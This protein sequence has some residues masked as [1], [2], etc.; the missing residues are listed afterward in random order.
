[1]EDYLPLEKHPMQVKNLSPSKLKEVNLFSV[2][3]IPSVFFARLWQNVLICGVKNK[4]LYESLKLIIIEG[5]APG[6]I[7]KKGFL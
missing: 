5:Q 4:Q 7:N 3:K 6:N 1:M 2:C